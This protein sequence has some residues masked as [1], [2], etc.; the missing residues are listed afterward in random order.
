MQVRQLCE[1]LRFCSKQHSEEVLEVGINSYASD[2]TAN[3]VQ[4]RSF[5]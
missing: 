5:L 2:S 1:L 4:L 3:G